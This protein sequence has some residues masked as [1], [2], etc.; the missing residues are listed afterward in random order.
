MYCILSREESIDVLVLYDPSESCQII[1]YTQFW[2]YMAALLLTAYMYYVVVEMPN[3][4]N[5]GLSVEKALKFP[6]TT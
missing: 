6:G 1:L 4:C 5:A 2:V 3:K